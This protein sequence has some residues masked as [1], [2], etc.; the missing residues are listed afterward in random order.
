MLFEV[1]SEE[2]K[3][4]FNHDPNPFISIPYIQL[5]SDKVD[6]LVYLVNNRDKSI[7]GLAGGIKNGKLLSPFSA[8]FGGFHYRNEKIHY[9]KV[10]EFVNDLKCY[11]QNNNIKKIELILPPDFYCHS[12]NAKTINALLRSHYIMLTPDITSLGNLE[13]FAGQFSDRKSRKCYRQALDHGLLF[14]EAKNLSEKKI[15]YNIVKEN[16]AWLNR[17][18]SVPFNEIMNTSK[19][20]PVDF[21]IVTNDQEEKLAAAIFYRG[22]HEIVQ[23]VW[24]GDTKTGRQL[25]AMDFMC[26]KLWSYYKELGY[27]Y[28]DVG[29]STEEGIPN[30]GLLRFKETLDATSALRHRFVWELKKEI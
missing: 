27:K 9:S 28:I 2:Y 14:A 6:K 16:R 1:N 5:N 21:F 19:L 24:W 29:I 30:D 15:A 10:Y 3:R 17:E 12:N 11:V 4:S 26:N 22:H 13:N 7:I 23:A 18:V 25:R 20:W 8:P